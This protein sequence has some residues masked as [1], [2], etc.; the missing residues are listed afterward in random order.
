MT[1]G[2]NKSKKKD[3]KAKSTKSASGSQSDEAKKLLEK[4]NAKADA[5]QC[6]FC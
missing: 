3:A 2:I 6:P 5:D 4:M 1:L